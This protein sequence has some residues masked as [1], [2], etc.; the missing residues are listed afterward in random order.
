MSGYPTNQ[1]LT[2][3]SV[4]LCN[5]FDYSLK[6]Q[7]DTSVIFKNIRVAGIFCLFAWWLPLVSAQAVK[8]L[9]QK[10]QSAQASLF[11]HKSGHIVGRFST[12]GKTVVASVVE[13]AYRYQLPMAVEYADR[14]ATTRPLNLEFHNQ[15][16]R[17]IL[18][19]IVRQAPR[20]RVSFSNGIVDIFSPEAREDAS[21]LLNAAIKDFSVTEME[22][23]EA[24]FQL[25]CALSHEVNSPW[26]G[27]SLAVGQWEPVRITL[28]LQN[29]K[30]YEVL[31]AIVAQNGR[32]IWTVTASPEKT[33][34]LQSGGIWYIYP[35]QQPFAAT[36]SERLARMQR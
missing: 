20:F 14:D 35:L 33:S 22:T 17:R 10:A 36:A 4:A 25:F 23:R 13:L 8:P 7:L 31:N 5:A 16:V 28:H 19:A 6:V 11:E 27:G 15:S 21:N 24:D 32:A 30:V 18:E 34:N 9:D 1:E 3:D 29:A 2:A 26:C 12:S